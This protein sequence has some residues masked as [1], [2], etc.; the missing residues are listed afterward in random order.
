M[1][2]SLEK[3]DIP[4]LLIDATES[5]EKITQTILNKIKAY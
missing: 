1:K 3:L 5:M 2:K 4:Y